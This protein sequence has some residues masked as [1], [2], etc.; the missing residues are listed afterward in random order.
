LAASS[1]PTVRENATVDEMKLLED[2]RAAV[3]PPDD[4]VLAQA[5]SRI[6]ATNFHPS[7]GRAGGPRRRVRWPQ[8]AVSGAAVAAI[9]VTLSVVLPG[10]ADGTFATKAWAVERNPNGTVT[11]T[12]TVDQQFQDPAGLQRALREDGVI[13]YVQM[14]GTVK[15]PLGGELACSYAHLDKAPAATQMAVITS[16]Q[17]P[18]ESNQRATGG[19]ASNQT[20]VATNRPGQATWTIHPSAM[21]RGSSILFADWV[22]SAFSVLMNPAVLSTDAAPV[23]APTAAS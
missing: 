11:V 18:A 22:S 9:A 2:F 23:C 14:N 20:P 6:L 12:V 8:L 1:P 15:G 7:G 10:G 17:T 4:E 21:P 5:R 19:I 16:N 13:A 3:A